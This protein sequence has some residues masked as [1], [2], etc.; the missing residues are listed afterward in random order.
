MT[1]VIQTKYLVFPVNKGAKETVLQFLENDREIYRLNIR[2]DTENPDFFAYIDVSRFEKKT[3][4]LRCDFETNIVVRESDEIDI[5]NMYGERYRPQVHFTAKNGWIN[6][7]N[8]LVYLNGVYHLFYQYNPAGTYWANMHWGHAVSRDLLHWEEQNVALF[9]DETG[10]MYSGCA[11]VDEKKLLG[12]GENIGILYYT[13]TDPCSQWM[14]VSTDG[15]KTLKRYQETPIIPHFYNR[16]RDPKVIFCDEMNC[17]VMALYVD[18]DRYT[19]FKSTDLVSW[20]RFFDYTL[21]GMREFPDILKFKKEK[22]DSLYVV[23]SNNDHYIVLSVKNGTF[24]IE[25]KMKT[26]WSCSY[27]HSPQ[28]FFG[29]P[30][31]RCVRMIWEIFDENTFG[32]NFVGQLLALEYRLDEVGGEYYLAATPLPEM[33]R[34]YRKSVYRRDIALID[35]PH[36]EQLEDSAQ[37]VKLSGA[38]SPSA[39]LR[40]TVFDLEFEIDFGKNEFRYPDGDCSCPLVVAGNRFELTL[41]VDRTGFE[42]FADG[43]RSCLYGIVE[44][45]KMNHTARQFMIVCTDG[46]Y[47]VDSLDI[48]SLESIW[49][50]VQ[51]ESGGMT[52]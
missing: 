3:V 1:L 39:H 37:C 18:E 21:P 9:P 26:L 36:T 24:V 29:M 52:E 10:Q 6:D 11:V 19:M 30:D 38:L 13:A 22:E 27:N 51:G 46:N 23:T 32:T 12:L 34:L 15:F 33:E 14:C 4:T 31:G 20:E 48:H 42:V 41:L 8:G 40:M 49:E 28:S 17:Y 7:P 16:E 43:G 35:D 25:Q 2:L 50:S 47:F 5:K 44:K 45:G